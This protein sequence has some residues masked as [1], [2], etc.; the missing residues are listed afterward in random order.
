MRKTARWMTEARALWAERPAEVPKDAWPAPPDWAGPGTDPHQGIRHTATTWREGEVQWGLV[1]YATTPL[2]TR[3]SSH[4]SAAVIWS[5]DPF[6]H[7]DP[8]WLD[9]IRERYWAVRQPDGQAIEVDI[10]TVFTATPGWRT[11]EPIVRND[12]RWYHTE[13]VP[14]LLSL[15]RVVYLDNVILHAKELPGQRLASELLPIVRGSVGARTSTRLLPLRFWPSEM[16][17]AW[18]ATD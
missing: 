5:E 14:P 15:G 18:E 4:G 3:G 6:I 7:D 8:L 1:I 9:R 10:D 13:R 16:R 2:W 12:H 17:Q 11:V